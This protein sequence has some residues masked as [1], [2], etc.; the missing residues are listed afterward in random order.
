MGRS[1]MQGTPWHYEVLRLSQDEERRSKNKCIYN[2]KGNCKIKT[3]KCTGVTHCEYYKEASSKLTISPELIPQ[4]KERIVHNKELTEEDYNKLFS[5][6]GIEYS[7]SLTVQIE[8]EPLKKYKTSEIP[9]DAAI[10]DKGYECGIGDR[11]EVSGISILV[12]KNKLIRVD[13]SK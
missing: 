5:S 9:N 1:S 3:M 2:K 8:N 11:F 7:G 13:K 12:I 10:F 6:T 4:K